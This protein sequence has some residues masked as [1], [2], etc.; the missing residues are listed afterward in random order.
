MQTVMTF[1]PLQRHEKVDQCSDVLN[2]WH[3]SPHWG[4]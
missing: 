3:I 2:A 1:L 4:N